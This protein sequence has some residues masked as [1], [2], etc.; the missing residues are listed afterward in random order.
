VA[1]VDVCFVPVVDSWT[2]GTEA[3]LNLRGSW[4]R[5]VRGLFRV[6]RMGSS[7]KVIECR[8]C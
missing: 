6:G 4:Y 1:E 3:L 5:I 2:V 8:H 7:R